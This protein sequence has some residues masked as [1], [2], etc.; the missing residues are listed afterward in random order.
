MT[1]ARSLTFRLLVPVLATTVLLYLLVFGWILVDARRRALV[2]AETRAHETAI[3]CATEVAAFIDRT[4]Q[5]P[6]AEQGVD[7][8]RPAADA[9]RRAGRARPLH[10]LG[11]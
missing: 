2:E 8:R 11:A 4:F 7:H 3:R 5:I 6:R 9:R 1:S 10:A